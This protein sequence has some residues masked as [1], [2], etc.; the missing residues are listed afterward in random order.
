MAE[1]DKGRTNIPVGSKAAAGVEVKP[2]REPRVSSLC[3]TCIYEYPHC[4]GDALQGFKT[5]NGT[6]VGCSKHPKVDGEPVEPEPEPRGKS[7]PKPI[8]ERLVEKREIQ[9][10]AAHESEEIIRKAEL[11]KEATRKA[12]EK[13]GTGD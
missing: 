5:E 6:I 10:K 11:I 8:P 12:E 4:G 3:D 2:K 9:S 13:F 1:R 7:K